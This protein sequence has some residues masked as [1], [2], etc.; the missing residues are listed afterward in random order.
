MV[1]SSEIFEAASWATRVESVPPLPRVPF[2]SR[3][4]TAPRQYTPQVLVKPKWFPAYVPYGP[5]PRPPPCSLEQAA[6]D[7]T[8]AERLATVDQHAV[9][10]YE[11]E[12]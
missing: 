6:G 2:C 10:S 7:S 3:L 12:V 8:G 11:T 1:M 5:Y 9:K 4:G